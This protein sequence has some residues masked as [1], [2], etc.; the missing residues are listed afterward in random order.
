MPELVEM[1]GGVN[2]FGEAGKHSPWMTWEELVTKDPDIIFVSPCGFDI[3]R[4]LQEMHLLGGRA[5]WKSLKAVAGGRV[6][7]ADGNQYFNRPGPRLAASL[8]I[9]AEIIHPNVFHF[10]HEGNGW[11]RY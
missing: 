10:G 4:T 5:E 11:V 9:L 1:A 2:L 8:E 3:Q 7:V 6:I